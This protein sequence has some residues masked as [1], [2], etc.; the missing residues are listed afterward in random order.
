VLI[1]EDNPINQNL[2]LRV[3][4]GFGCAADVVGNGQEAVDAVG[5]RAYDVV[6]MDIEMPVMDGLEAMRRIVQV[7][8]DDRP[9]L[10]A[11]TANAFV[12]DREACFAAG[13]DDYVSKPIRIEAL[14]V[15]LMK[16][17]PRGARSKPPGDRDDVL[18][19]DAIE[20][21]CATAG[22]RGFAGELM[23]DFVAQ[24]DMETARLGG[25]SE[26]ED[27]RRLAH[28]LKSGAATFGATHLA[29][30][31]AELEAG[32]H[33]GAYDLELGPA[34]A[35]EFERVRPALVST[36]ERLAL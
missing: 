28:T 7:H 2:A 27:I 16:V 33:V 24:A 17:A 3:L 35:T 29:K 6:L 30:L 36:A 22:D 32:A 15:A 1:A 11:M 20:R 25:L 26:L 9:R 13:A 19:A 5:Q 21:V 14:D 23:S 18:D 10:I 34:V 8:G 31:C 12:A 4:A